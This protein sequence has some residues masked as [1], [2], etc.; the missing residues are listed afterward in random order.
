MTPKTALAE[1][2]RTA[3]TK[4]CCACAMHAVCDTGKPCD[5]ATISSLHFA[6]LFKWL[7]H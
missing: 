2:R 7:I 3:K 5:Q 6:K 4:D 1:L